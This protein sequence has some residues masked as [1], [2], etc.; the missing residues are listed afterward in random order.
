MVIKGSLIKDEIK[1]AAIKTWEDKIM[2]AIIE[3]SS[4]MKKSLQIISSVVE[5]LQEIFD[6]YFIESIKYKKLELPKKVNRY[7]NNF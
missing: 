4:E 1:E 2:E 7:I 5:D 3:S 6:P